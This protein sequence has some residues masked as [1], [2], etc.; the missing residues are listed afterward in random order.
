M[1][2][3]AGKKSRERESYKVWTPQL[4]DPDASDLA[5]QLPWVL[6]HGKFDKE[7][8]LIGHSSGASLILPLLEALDTKVS[9]A[10]LVSGFLTRGGSRPPKAVRDEDKYN[11][12]K[13]RANVGEIYFINASNDPWGCNDKQG[14][15]MFNNLGGVLIINNDGHMGSVLFK[16]PYKEF[17]LL[18]KLIL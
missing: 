12:K 3:L 15:K 9:K 13:I 6:N 1:V 7:T 5:I 16:Q 4:P 17:P 18:L 8:V 2:P 11:W 14:R 10:I